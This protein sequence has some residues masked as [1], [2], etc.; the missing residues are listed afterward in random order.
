MPKKRK[1]TLIKD[2]RGFNYYQTMSFQDT[3]GNKKKRV[4]RYLGKNMTKSELTSRK[5]ELDKHYDYID[6]NT[7]KGN[8]QMKNPNTLGVIL[9]AY[10]KYNKKRVE[11]LELSE[12]TCRNHR[13]YT[14][15][16]RKFIDKKHPKILVNSIT[17]KMIK[18]YVLFRKRQKLSNNT[19][20]ND[21]TYIKTFFKWCIRERY[22][23][24]NP[25]DHTIKQPKY[26]P[27]TLDQVPIGKEWDILYKFISKSLSFNPTTD[28]ERKK[29][30]WFNRNT[31]FKEQVFLMLNTAMRGGEVQI[32]KWK[33]GDMDYGTPRFP[34]CH[35]NRDMK[36]ATIYFK[37]TLTTSFE[38]NEPTIN[39]LKERYDRRH[40]KD[41][42]VFSN[43]QTNNKYNKSQLVDN[44]NRLCEGLGLVDK[45]TQKSLFTPHAIRHGVISQ[46]LSSGNHSIQDISKVVAR[47]SK[48]GTTYDIYGHF[49]KGKGK[50]ILD[51]LSNK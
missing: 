12:V 38:F 49:Q 28:D 29:W 8:P 5:K 24:D 48:I 36:S 19:I 43:P 33:K 23:I 44:F 18:D 21:L 50:S 45:D 51:T 30:T 32:L 13:G 47:H 11:D 46:L 42:Y 34:Y 39:M 27:R 17:T 22:I 7:I 25:Y 41:I 15:Q 40:P 16:F 10:D 20:K 14:E 2:N 31:D 37:R 3:I 1:S 9:K 6:T 4:M 26:V 35:L